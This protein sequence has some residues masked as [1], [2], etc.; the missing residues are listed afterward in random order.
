M[1]HNAATVQHRT[2]SKIKKSPMC[3]GRSGLP[4]D[5]PGEVGITYLFPTIAVKNLADR[6]IVGGVPITVDLPKAIPDSGLLFLFLC[7]AINHP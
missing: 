2:H 5:T 7:F 3:I 6:Q 4:G 1:I